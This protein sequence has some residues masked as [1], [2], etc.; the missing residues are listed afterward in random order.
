MTKI[1]NKQIIRLDGNNK[2]LEVM[3]NAFGI[4]KV[5]INFREYDKTKSKGNRVVAQVD[6][7]VNIA[8]AL[9]LCQEI[10]SGK[11]KA[12]VETKNPAWKS[13]GGIKAEKAKR[14]DGMALARVIKL[15]KSN[16][17]FFLTGECG[18]GEE[19]EKGLI[20]PKYGANPEQKV[21]IALDDNQIKQLA[22]TLQ[23]HIGAYFSA[24][25]TNGAYEMEYTPSTK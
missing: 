18:A 1:L 25:Y 14:E 20:V 7:Y 3:G 9:V 24:Q 21:S 12:L 16:K 17:G 15:S 13:Q 2:F 10:I 23:M 8:D 5:Q 19:D 6:C 22:L 11:M 4:D